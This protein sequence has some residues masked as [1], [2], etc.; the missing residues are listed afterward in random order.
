ML[1]RKT[2]FMTSH[3]RSNTTFQR[4][5]PCRRNST[6]PSSA[7]PLSPQQQVSVNPEKCSLQQPAPFRVLVFSSVLC[8]RGRMYQ[9]VR[10]IP[11]LV[12][13]NSK[14]M[15]KLRVLKVRSLG[16]TE[17]FKADKDPRK[18][19]LGVGAYRDEHGK[20][21]VLPSVKKVHDNLSGQ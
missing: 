4:F 9:R 1:T 15:D 11:F 3:R 16:V 6:P 5:L 7:P 17:A 19:N 20:P 10:L 18:I 8:R 12:W 2:R 13:H 21:Y 14:N